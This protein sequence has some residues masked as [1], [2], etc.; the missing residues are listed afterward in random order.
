MTT[1]DIVMVIDKPHL[2]VKLHKRLLEVDL[3]EG[4]RKELEDVLEAT[5]ALRKSLGFLF[6]TIIPLDVP[7]KE[8]E[9]VYVD[10]KGRVKM[11]IPSRKDI[12]IPLEP[13]E[14]KR[15]VEKMNE[16]IPREKERAIRELRKAEK[17]RK[18]VKPKIA[19]T[20]SEAAGYQERIHGA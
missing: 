12:V 8:I 14:S 1:E 19:A 2:I 16:W 17:I 11:A 15:L 20:E 5:P 9:S 4:V 3:K 18:V 6:Q 13:N 10:K 7:L